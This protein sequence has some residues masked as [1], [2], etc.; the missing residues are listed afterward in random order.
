M[1]MLP[2]ENYILEF[3]NYG[4]IVILILIAVEV[5][6]VIF[7]GGKKE[8]EEPKT[9]EEKGWWSK[10]REKAKNAARKEKTKLLNE[11]IV[12]QK[13]IDLLDGT[14][15]SAKKALD[16]VNKVIDNEE[17][18]DASERDEIVSN[19]DKLK[20]DLE[21][22]KGEYRKVGKVT[23]RQEK[24]FDKLLKVLKKKEGEA[25]D[26]KT[27][28]FKAL[29]GF[30][31]N[32]LK[33]HQECADE[34][35]IVLKHYKDIS[36]NIG[37]LK[38]VITFPAPLTSP[39]SVTPFFPLFPVLDEIRANLDHAIYELKNVYKKQEDVYTEVTAIMSKVKQLW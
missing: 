18:K 32:I 24:K 30:E 14:V 12:E 25:E 20:S 28:D 2:L 10:W 17:I 1:A 23:W 4:V 5:F 13:E 11:T 33:L 26:F 19:L 35:G 9:G 6:K 38:A 22:A 31:N 15:Q 37:Q 16:S 36:A 29:K 34:L 21:A 39:S 8:G 27:E 3:V 7:S